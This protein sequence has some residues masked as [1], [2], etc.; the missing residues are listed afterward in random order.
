MTIIIITPLN[1]ICYCFQVTI[2]FYLIQ[3]LMEE[4]LVWCWLA[5][6]ESVFLIWLQTLISGSLIS[7]SEKNASVFLKTT[8]NRN[9]FV[10]KMCHKDSECFLFKC[11]FLFTEMSFTKE[12]LNNLQIIKHVVNTFDSVFLITNFFV[13]FRLFKS[14]SNTTVG[15]GRS[16]CRTDAQ[17]FCFLS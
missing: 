6:H 14:S 2:F 5:L 15:E 9:I 3:Q 10:E 16:D 4:R 17:I 13:I 1:Y 12:Y 8:I 11:S 7:A